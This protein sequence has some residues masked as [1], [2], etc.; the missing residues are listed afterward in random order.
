MSEPKSGAHSRMFAFMTKDW[1]PR[2]FLIDD[3]IWA[4]ELMLGYLTEQVVQVARPS[5][6]HYDPTESL[7]SPTGR[8]DESQR[9]IDESIALIR[10][11]AERASRCEAVLTWLSKNPDVYLPHMRDPRQLTAWGDEFEK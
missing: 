5:H 11:C 3:C 2:D 6:P 10:D 9:E 8:G 7:H 1:T 4:R